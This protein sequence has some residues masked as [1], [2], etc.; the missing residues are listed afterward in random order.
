[1]ESNKINYKK[2]IVAIKTYEKRLLINVQ[3]KSNLKREIKIL[4]MLKH[5]NIINLY[6]TIKT[7]V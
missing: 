5:P 2:R 7:T 4:S 1:V 6:Q 3:L